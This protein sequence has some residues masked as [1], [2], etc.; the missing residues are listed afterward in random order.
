MKDLLARLQHVCNDLKE[1]NEVKIIE[2]Y[3][4]NAKRYTIILT[5]K[6]IFF[7]IYLYFI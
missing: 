4:Y 1:R 6:I 7:N 3:G 5:S 2:K